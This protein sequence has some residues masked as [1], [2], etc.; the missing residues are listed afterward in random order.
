MFSVFSGALDE[1]K[2]EEEVRMNSKG[3][4]VLF[5][6]NNTASQ[7]IANEL[8]KYGFDKTSDNEWR[9][10][11]VKIIK[12]NVPSVLEIPTD[13]DTEFILV[14]SSH[15][16][17]K[18]GKMLTV[19]FPGNWNDAKFGG[20]ERTLNIACAR[21]LKMLI[22]ELETENRKLKW[23]LVL[24]AD[25][26]GPTC[27][28]P[29]MFVEIGS[30]EEEWKDEDAA[31]IVAKAVSEFLSKQETENRKPDAGNQDAGLK[32]GNQQPNTVFAIGGGHYA[33]EFTEM[34]LDPEMNIAIGHILPKYAIDKLDEDVFRQAIEKN[35]EKIDKIVMLKESTNV[36]QKKKIMELA[37][38][39]G[40]EIEMR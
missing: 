34:A 20:D 28:V 7:N 16:S 31:K 29:I 27:D 24:E 1:R 19:H 10:A 33:K 3:I 18:G 12:T 25:H 6:P 38:K 22:T 37:E 8:I 17:V 35:V 15:K 5:T 39:Y 40:T 4:T 9:R 26:H 36:S 30:T 21:M 23:P 14:L 11:N 13:F 32:T 2:Y